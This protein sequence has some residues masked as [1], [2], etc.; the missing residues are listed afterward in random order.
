M[1]FLFTWAL[2]I[3][4]VNAIWS[5]KNVSRTDRTACKAGNAKEAI[6]FIASP[7]PITMPLLKYAGEYRESSSSNIILHPECSNSRIGGGSSNALNMRAHHSAC[8]SSGLVR[9]GGTWGLT[10]PTSRVPFVIENK[11]DKSLRKITSAS[12]I[13]T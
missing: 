4:R 1:S 3:I 9:Y 6:R 13:I 12:A 7:V 10:P 8:D 5:K 2:Y 11:V